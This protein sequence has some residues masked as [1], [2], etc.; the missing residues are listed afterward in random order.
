MKSEPWANDYDN[1]DGDDSGGSIGLLAIF[2][3]GG[4]CSGGGDDG[5][6]VNMSSFGSKLFVAAAKMR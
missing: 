1:S 6:D 2:E 3:G 5:D 4:G